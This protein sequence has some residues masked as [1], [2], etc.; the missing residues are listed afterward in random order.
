MVSDR[1]SMLHRTSVTVA[2]M[3]GL[4]LP[5]YLPGRGMTPIRLLR[6]STHLNRGK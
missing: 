1:I 4:L 5:P 2:R 3:V 6:S